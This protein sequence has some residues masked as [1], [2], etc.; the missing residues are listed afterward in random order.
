MNHLVSLPVHFYEATAKAATMAPTSTMLMPG[1]VVPEAYT[2]RTK[3]SKSLA[4][5]PGLSHTPPSSIIATRAGEL[6]MDKAGRTLWIE[7]SGGRYLPFVGDLVIATIHHSSAD[8]YHCEVTP[9]TPFAL[10]G[11]LAFEGATKKTRPILNTG[12][13]VYARVKTADKWAD[14]ELECCDSNTGKA[15]G[16]GPLKDGTTFDVSLD[17]ARRL[18]TGDAEKSGLVV[19]EEFGAKIK[20]EVA[21]GRNGVVWVN[22]AK[23]RETIAIGRALQQTDS[24]QLDVAGQK[25]LV[26]SL[27]K[28]I[29]A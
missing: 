12:M 16:M 6:C 28:D 18:I 27:L 20:F 13:L 29:A 9:H 23:V 7:S 22:A 8:I 4:L 5:G 15:D 17:F 24:R 1:H 2:A 26:K 11:Q 14:V 25:K 3:S 21:I 19:L 10:L